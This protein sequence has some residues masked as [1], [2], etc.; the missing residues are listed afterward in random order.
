MSEAPATTNGHDPDIRIITP[1]FGPR[2][3]MS[4]TKAASPQSRG[5]LGLGISTFD[6]LG[7]SGL[8][9]WGGFV[10]EEWLRE[11]QEGR[12]AA[13]VF[14]EM[15]DSDPVIGAILYAIQMLIRRVDWWAEPQGSEQAKWLESVMNDM[16]YSW[17]DTLGEIIS[18]LTYGWSYHETVYKLRKGPNN[19]IVKN[20]KFNDGTIGL[21]RL[22]IRSQDSLWKWVFDDSGD[23]IGMIQNP[24]PDYQLRFIP[25]EKALLFRTNIF[26]QNPEGRSILRNA[27]RPW[28]FKRNLEN[29]EGIGVE[30]DLAG[31]PTLKA[32]EGVDIWDA[33]DPSMSNVRLQ[34]Q[35]LVSSIRRDEQEGIILP[36]GWELELLSTG[37]RRQFDT[38]AIISRYD[39]RIAMSVLAD[40]VLMGQDKVGSYAL[41]VTKKDLFAN[42]LEA[43]L[44]IIG[45]V[46]QTQLIPRLWKLNGFTTEMPEIKHG[47]VDTIDL[48]TLGNYVMRLS[49]AGAPFEWSTTMPYLVEQAGMPH[50]SEGHDYDKAAEDLISSQHPAPAPFGGGDKQD[51]A[52]SR[53]VGRSKAGAGQKD[54]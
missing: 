52:K 4:F 42:S 44:D 40:M 5:N 27:Y 49:G 18:F 12:R 7:R 23:A 29:I 43:Y 46:F 38:N 1:D 28:Y 15:S 36:F 25:I 3:A 48:D 19:S 14:R 34:A 53:G 39:N 20:S 31:M 6:E 51:P 37:G 13:E 47:S 50:A 9:H 54:G 33:S 22:P 35:A 16:Q 11:L 24:P 41:A 30:R 32:P 10:F 2:E 45:S 8:R 21:G 26:K 17:T